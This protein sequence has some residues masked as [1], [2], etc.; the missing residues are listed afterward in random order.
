MT[1][2]QFKI[3]KSRIFSSIH[4]PRFLPFFAA[5]LLMAAC[6][7][8][9][10][11]VVLVTATPFGDAP[12]IGGGDT[13]PSSPP[14]TDF[15]P[16]PIPTYAPTPTF[17]PTPNPTRSAIVDPSQD[18]LHVVQPGDTLNQIALLYGV[19]VESIIAANTL[20]DPDT[21]SVGQTLIIPTAIQQTGPGF[22]IIPDR[23]LVY[24]PALRGFSVA[25]FLADR[26]CYLCSYSEVLDGRAWTGAEIVERVALEQSISPRLLLALLE[27][28][29]GWISRSDI[30]DESALYPMNYLERPTQIYG[31]YQQLDW[32]G[33]M[34]S[35]G[36]YGWRQRGLSAVV[37]A[38]G[39]RVGLDPTL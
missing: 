22:K 12:P 18:Q 19:S 26:D 10:S 28:N 11:Y 3:I 7:P 21:L 30:P 20:L 23:E 8:S 2:S 1:A 24:G 17:I 25:E 27:Y 13:A 32:A 15:P 29:G 9:R 35:T 33:K 5:I 36:Y 38:D 4:P 16:T 6:G 34:L 31:L 14:Q 39:T 37:L